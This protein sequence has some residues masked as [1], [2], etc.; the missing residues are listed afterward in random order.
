MQNGGGNNSVSSNKREEV[1]DIAT[2]SQRNVY[3]VSKISKD[4]TMINSSLPISVYELN[5]NDVDVI[6]V[7]Y[8]CEGNYR[9]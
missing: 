7:S 5:S 9:W 4:G 2:D 3:I 6:L 8:S 1:I